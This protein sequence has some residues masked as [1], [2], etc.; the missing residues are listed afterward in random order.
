MERA[1][2]CMKMIE[3]ENSI[4]SINIINNQIIIEQVYVSSAGRHNVQ[5]SLA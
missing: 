5:I 1:A 4:K 3:I 2:K